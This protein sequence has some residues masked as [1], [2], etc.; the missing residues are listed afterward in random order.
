[1][2]PPANKDKSKGKMVWFAGGPTLRLDRSQTQV[3]NTERREL[4]RVE[5][6]LTSATRRV[7]MWA[8]SSVEAMVTAPKYLEAKDLEAAVRWEAIRL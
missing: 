8:R 6:D 3:F 1:M 7:T 2:K 4:F 5:F